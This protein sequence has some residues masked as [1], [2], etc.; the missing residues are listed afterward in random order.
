MSSP[1]TTTSNVIVQA[2]VPEL[3]EIRSELEGAL[4]R[5]QELRDALQHQIE[6]REHELEAA[7]DLALR[8]AEAE[9]AATRSLPARRE[10][11][12][13]EQV[14]TD[15]LEQIANERR[16]LNLHRTELVGRGGAAR[17]ARRPGR[18]DARRSRVRPTTIARRPPR[19]SRASS[20]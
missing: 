15:Q 3:A 8:E 13:R 19:S 11:E 16:E 14:L 5:E 17:G 1:S 10:L 12:R 18:L 6:A 4:R 20:G 2:S 7:R 9:Q